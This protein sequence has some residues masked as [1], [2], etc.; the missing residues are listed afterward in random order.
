MIHVVLTLP[1]PIRLLFVPYRLS[2]SPIAIMYDIDLSAY[3]FFK[4]LIFFLFT[5]CDWYALADTAIGCQ[6]A[7]TELDF[8]LSLLLFDCII[9]KYW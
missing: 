1:S 5:G 7:S 4:N 6:P 3:G 9:L 2:Y 8:M